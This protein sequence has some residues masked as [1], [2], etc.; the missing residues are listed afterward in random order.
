MKTKG[1]YKITAVLAMLFISIVAVAQPSGVA[2]PSSS[3]YTEN[4]NSTP[5]A[6]GNGY[7]AGWGA[8]NK[9]A[10]DPTMGVGSASSTTG[11]N[12]NYGSS[13]GILGSGTNY[14]PGYIIL[15]LTNTTGKSGL[16]I[17]YD[18][19]KIREQT[20]TCTFNLEVSTT[21]ATSGFSAISGGAYSSGSITQGTTTSFSNINISA[22]DNKSGPVYIRWYYESSGSG[23]RDGVALDNVSISWDAGVDV[24]TPAVTNIGE[25][26]ADLSANLASN[27]GTT[28]LERGFVW[29]TTTN[30]LV[31]GGGVTKVTAS[32]TSTGTFTS[33]V[34][35]LPA[36]TRVYFK[37]FARNSTGSFYTSE[38][39]FITQS[40]EPTAYPGS[41]TATAI[42]KNSIKLDW[43]QVAGANGY[44]IIQRK[45]D[46]P[47]GTPAD[48]TAYTLNQ[49][50]GDGTIVGLVTSGATVT[51]TINGLIQGTR[52]YYTLFPFGYNGTNTETYNY[53]TVPIIPLAN[54]STW[55]FPPS[56]KST[57]EGVSGSEAAGISSLINDN[58]T[59]AANGTQVWKLHVKDGGA[60]LND[61]DDLPTIVTRITLNKA[62]KN[63]VASWLN[64]LQ[65]AGLVDDSTGAVIA[66]GTITANTITFNGLTV[67]AADN[68]Y[69]PLSVRLSLKAIAHK[70]RDT[71]HFYVDSVGTLTKSA[72]ESS[73]TQNFISYSDSSKN[74]IDVV[75]T[76]LRFITQPQTTVEAGA[77]LTNTIQVEAVDAFNTRDI[78]FNGNISLTATD[79]NLIAT[80]RSITAVKGLAIFDT[81]RFNRISA[82]DTLVA[83]A[84]ALTLAKSN[85]FVVEASK[86]SDIIAD[87]GFVY[88]QNIIH[89]DYND[90]DA[91]SLTNSL[92]V[93]S[94]LL[95]DG[96]NND[97]NDF[98]ST[99][100][101]GL[102]FNISKSYLIRKAALFVGSTKV[103]EVD[104]VVTVGAN[105]Q[106]VFTGFAMTAPDNDS[107]RF[108]L[109]V[110]FKD[111][112]I[113]GDN[114]GFAVVTATAD[115]AASQFTAANAGGAAS[116][117]AGANNK[118]DVIG[119]MIRFIQQPTDVSEG[120]AQLPPPSVVATD[121]LGNYDLA[122]YNYTLKVLG[123]SIFDFRAITSANSSNNGVATFSRLIYDI[124]ATGVKISVKTTGID[125]TVSDTFEVMKPTWF[126]TVQSGNWSDTLV[127]EFSKNYGTNWQAANETPDYSKHG[128]ITIRAAHT[129]QMDGLTADANT[130][131]EL[132]VESN[133][134]LITPQG[135]Y[136]KLTVVDGLATDVVVEGKLLHN[137]PVAGNG[138]SI[139]A[140]ATMLVKKGGAVELAAFGDAAH[141][142][143]NINI[144][145][146]DSSF[147]IHNT[148]IT[149]TIG[150]VTMFPNAT[151]TE[152]PVFRIAQNYTYPGSFINPMATL[153]INGLLSI[154]TAKTLTING[155]GERLLRN[156]IIGAGNLVIADSSKVRITADAQ[157]SGSG[158]ISVN[159]TKAVF[160]IGTASYTELKNNKELTTT[161]A[162][163]ISVSG[164][165]NGFTNGF[166]GNATAKTE[167]G[168]TV[169]TANTQGLGGL[170]NTSGAKTYHPA[171]DYIFNGTVAQNIGNT[172]GLT[173]R[174]IKVNNAF[175]LTLGDSVTVTDTLY[176]GQSNVTSSTNA[177]LTIAA[178][179]V[180]DGYSA[181]S[182][183]NGPLNL[184]VDNAAVYYPVGKTTYGPVTYTSTGTPSWITLEY[185]N[186]NPN[187]NGFDTAKRGA[188]L[189][190]IKANEYWKIHSSA[191]TTGNIE[192]PYTSNSAITGV[193][194]L[195]IRVVSWNGTRW[196]SE[197]PVA[198]TATST[199]VVADGLTNYTVFTVGVDSTC[200]IPAV[201]AFAANN[202]CGARNVV[203][204]AASGNGVVRW[205]I[206]AND[207]Q[208]FAQGTSVNVGTLFTDSV[209]YA[210][211]KNIGCYSNRVAY[212]V[213]INTPPAAPLLSGTTQLCNATATVLNADTLGTNNWYADVNATLP[214]FTGDAFATGN[215]TNDT[216]FYV[217]KIQNG[218]A[219]TT[220]TRIDVS[221]K[222][223]ILSPVSNGAEVCSGA[224]AVVNAAAN[225]TIRW[226]ENT[227][228][229]TPFYSGT[230]YTTGVLTADSTFYVEAFDGAC[231]SPRIPVLA[232]VLAL[233]AAPAITPGAVC[234]GNTAQIAANGPGT[235][236][237]Y[238]DTTS[239][240]INSGNSFTTAPLTAT[241]TYYA[242]IFDGKCFSPK[243]AAL[244]EAFAIPGSA[245]INVP[246]NAPTNQTVAIQTTAVAQN[247][248]WDFG[249]DATPQTATGAGP[250][251]VK[252]STQ[253]SKTVKLKLWNGNSAVACSTEVQNFVQVGAGV[254]VQEIAGASIAVYPNPASSALTLDVVFEAAQSG[255]VLIT[256]ATGKT[257]YQ[258]AFE[259]VSGINK[260]LDVTGFA[261]GLY[262]L[263]VATE[264]GVSVHKVIVQ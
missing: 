167:A 45:G 250:H 57:I 34:T 89:T 153:A 64:T 121:S 237:W 236:Y 79:G 206:N 65:S 61:A 73:Q 12:Y 19:L 78:D 85:R 88:P 253:G 157:L 220:R 50:L 3:P 60:T 139:A 39:S 210:E 222:P 231:A 4:F 41:F 187:A 173:A 90:T 98:E 109:R 169:I 32:G 227:T 159:H 16:K 176:I 55:G 84:G 99:I 182:F 248:V 259:N 263:K 2:L 66:N 205:F 56:F 171:T 186:N 251:N 232:K 170:F 260:Q 142:A 135:A 224:K 24:N 129:V 156:G 144:T 261:K 258:T 162:N 238:N 108:S 194:I 36:G 52:Y 245:T 141:W 72:L 181:T 111:S 51:A 6:S 217:E 262:M 94:L 53:R 76:K 86:G 154:D 192:L 143:G 18:V 213:T 255:S 219:S 256:D 228:A 102:T 164:T 172:I 138:I 137:N 188:G 257:V 71:F 10:W 54:D 97:D 35:G 87:G 247:Y 15:V 208:P 112:A 233:P 155:G 80:S 212:S 25:T 128:R 195:N 110:T 8:N 119:R 23:S 221:V 163:G 246:A 204:L 240:A 225:H 242:A 13:I 168:A 74:T 150:A 43:T 116:L 1:I 122:V 223:G 5:G 47:T 44:L 114:F 158:K 105:K 177:I 201:P 229:S 200:A 106:L 95:R 196:I 33:S 100:L 252:W 30:P 75:A 147:Y 58:I 49:V 152:K 132:I 91:V 9:G 69:R 149:N 264:N 133:A 193:D 230:R 42:S 241:R 214:I 146:E 77:F 218:C 29:S 31:G 101:K 103:A 48:K 148:P 180:I 113:D 67:T 37:G 134:V 254:G 136:N 127:W 209:F 21:S 216:S 178:S 118:I 46:A 202:V 191:K 11:D 14:D 140:P 166:S 68:N 185:V 207:I 59:T 115:A 145:F 234:V 125:S 28:I 93:V 189:A 126:R 81:V 203:T 117:T 20:R 120:S 151:A 215:L 70:D 174:T 92:E 107:L 235:V 7:P 82:N 38:V 190:A 161:A 130:V 179:G 17:S 123:G 211:V 165:L 239:A 22:L 40:A 96:G 131:D 226:Y 183:I 160:Q 124:P 27:G 62:A 184:W 63:T 83:T 249:T 199:R 244:A 197:G 198:R 243:V 26:T 104:S 175:G